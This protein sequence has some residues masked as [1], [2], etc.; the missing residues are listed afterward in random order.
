MDIASNRKCSEDM[1]TLLYDNMF[2]LNDELSLKLV[3]LD[4]AL[5]G[6]K[7]GTS[8]LE[9]K[10]ARSLDSIKEFHKKMAEA[11]NNTVAGVKACDKQADHDFNALDSRVRRYRNVLGDLADKVRISSFSLFVLLLKSSPVGRCL[12]SREGHPRGPGH[13]DVRQALSLWTDEG[14]G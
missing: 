6:A 3:R 12:G 2:K 8:K 11:H 13:F 9:D 5:D 1:V 4:I 14:G 7:E 10:V